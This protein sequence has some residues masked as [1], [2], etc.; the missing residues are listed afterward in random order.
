MC[1]LLQE[2]DQHVDAVNGFLSP[3]QREYDPFSNTYNPGWRNHPNFCYKQQNFQSYQ[4][5]QF[6]QQ[7]SSSNSAMSM[8]KLKN[9][10]KLPSQT[11]VNPK[12]NVSAA[13]LRSGKELQDNPRQ[14]SRR[15]D[16]PRQVSRG[17]NHSTDLETEMT[18][19]EQDKSASAS[20]QSEPLIIKPPF[21][22][23]LAR[24]KQEKEEKE[25]L[26]TLRKVKVNIPLLDAIKQ[27]PRYAKLLKELCTNKRKLVGYQKIYM[28]EKCDLGVSINIMMPLLVFQS[29]NVGPLKET[30]VVIQLVDRAIVYPDGVLEDVLV[31]VD[32]LIFPADFYVIPMEDNKFSNFSDILLE[33]LFL[34]T[35]RTNI[36]IYDSTLTMEFDG[37]VIEFNV[38][39]DVKH[40]NNI[41]SVYR[42]DTS[43]LLVQ[44]VLKLEYGDELNTKFCENF[45]KSSS[46]N[47]K[48]NFDCLKQGIKVEH[49]SLPGQPLPFINENCTSYNLKLP[50][51]QIFLKPFYKGDH[52]Q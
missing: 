43:K 18:I 12:Q 6:Q 33:I 14:V 8:N 47:I 46:I 4:P 50:F 52:F 24:F 3:P 7:T 19:P 36:N 10:G 13:I 16:N 41:S 2:D 17:H 21:P 38:Y 45:G 48:K 20:E 22:Q 26:E 15:H 35:A 23:R 5:K 44:Q 9:Q 37:E 25:I 34:S 42:V 40:P 28:D 30:G 51:Q 49:E 27:V 32:N 1:P 29:L 11:I 31:Q 39:D